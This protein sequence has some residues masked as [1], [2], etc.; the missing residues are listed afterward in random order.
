[1][2]EFMQDIALRSDSVR[3]AFHSLIPLKKTGSAGAGSAFKMKG[4]GGFGNSPVKITGKGDSVK[5]I[6]QGI[7]NKSRKELQDIVK[8]NA[9]AGVRLQ[10]VEMYAGKGYP[11]I[12]SVAAASNLLSASGDPLAEINKLDKRRPIKI[13]IPPMLGVNPS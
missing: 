4:F 9:K 1:M 3:A 13:A 12:D 8:R 6:E 7:K 5:K 2:P 11:Q 10:D